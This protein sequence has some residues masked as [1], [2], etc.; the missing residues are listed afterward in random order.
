MV[1]INLY[2]SRIGTFFPC[3]RR[4]R[5]KYKKLLRIQKNEKYKTG[6]FLLFVMQVVV[7]LLLILA[8]FEPARY[9]PCEPIVHSFSSAPSRCWIVPATPYSQPGLGREA[10]LCTAQAVLQ[11]QTRGRKEKSN[12]KAKYVNGNKKRGIVN[13]HVNI[14]SLYNKVSEVKNLIKQE[15]PHILGIS[16]SEL[17]IHHSVNSL[18]VPGYD[19]LLPKSWDVLGKA[20]V[21]V[22]IKKTLV[23]EHLVDLEQAD[24]QTIWLR[25]GFKNTSK[26][27]FS[28]QYREHTNTLGNSMVAQRTTLEKQLLQWEEAVSYGN[29][30]SPNEVHIAGDMNLDSFKG[31]WLE[32]GYALVTLARMV[33]DCCNANNFTQMVDKITRIQYDS[34]RNQT[35]T[36]CIDHIYCNAKHRISP[37]KISSFGAS[38]HDV[39]SYTRYSKEPAA[40]ARTIRKRSYK[41]FKEVDYLRDVSNIDFTDVYCSKEVDDAA[42]LLTAKLVDVLNVHAPW[43]IFQQ[44]KCYSPWLTPETLKLMK[45]RDKYKDQAKELASTEG[46]DTSPEQALLW[47]KYRQL[48]NLVN[49]K[50]GQ[51]EI[52]YKRNKVNQCKDNPSKAWGLA[53]KYM[54]WSSPGPPSQLEVDKDKKITLYTK[55][56]DLASVMNEFFITKVQ[57]IVENLRKVPVDLSGCRNIMA[58]RKISLSLKFVTVKKVRKLLAGLKNKTSTGVDQLDNYSVKLA[59]DYIAGPL[60]HVITLSIMQQKFPSGWKYTKIVPLHKKEST[61][62]PKNYR[63]VAILSP[64]SKVLEKVLYEHVYDYFSRNKLFHPSLHGYR[65]GRSTMTALLTMYDKWVKAASKGQV[66]GVVLVDLSAAFDLV[67]PALLIQKLRIYGFE[68]DIINWISSY[69]TERFQAVW[70]DH[71]YSSFLCNHLGVPQGSNL[72]PLLFLVFFNDLPEFINEDIDCYADDST[73]GATAADI[74]EI[75]EKLSSDCSNLSNWMASNSF[76]LNADKTHFLTMGTKRRLQI[77]DQQLLVVMD[78]VTLD[79]SEDQKEL[80]LGITIQNDLEWSH[81]IKALVSKLKKRLAGLER[82]RYVM[83]STTKK[84]IVEGVFNSVLCYCLPLFGGCSNIEQKSLQVQQNKA[85]RIVLSMPPRSNREYMYSKL[86]WLTV[87]QLTVYHTLIAIYRIRLSEDPE[88]LAGILGRTSRQGQNIIIVENIKLGLVRNSFTFRGAIQWNNLP[89]TLRTEMKIGIFK[90]ALKKWVFENI[91]RFKD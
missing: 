36:S 7:K 62:K 29:P 26:I 50:T 23:Y 14:R 86:G 76:K 15:K 49:N 33:I 28:H 44:R 80:L 24:V 73:L 82:L 18:K 90:K 34:I 11:F 39:I 10:W 17:K 74:A 22:Y 43:V 79:E 30:D 35:H 68:E 75:G 63:P 85:A 57:K 42:A 6:V 1:D 84:N 9:L 3:S 20:R 21:V 51:E 87:N 60:H 12:F 37:V 65:G 16:E 78:G 77:L 67:S 27:Y 41:N 8:L 55:A 91:P 25:A 69:L 61:L 56:R 64:L 71:V 13:M 48:R 54:D 5:I 81:Q 31:K 46:K 66:S 83:G 88:Y 47:G 89:Q 45:E 59:A 53:K 70:I 2:R 40:P 52:R 32:P 19:L 4:N 72:G 38:D 58:D